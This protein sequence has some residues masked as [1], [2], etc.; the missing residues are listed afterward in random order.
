MDLNK[1]TRK[2]QEA[3][4]HA[5]SIALNLGQQ[6]IVPLHV[7][8]ALIE[9]E[10]TI[11][12]PVLNRLNV[13]IPELTEELLRRL[14]TIPTI[15]EPGQIFVSQEMNGVLMQASKESQKLEDEYMSTEHFLLALLQVK[16]DAQHLLKK[17]G[18]DYKGVLA[19]VK[20]LRG[21]HRVTSPEPETKYQALEKYTM[22]LTKLAREEKLDPV[23]GRDDEIRRAMQVLSRRTKNNPVLIGEPGTGKT[24]IVE[25]LAQRIVAGDVPDSLKNKEVVSLDIGLLLAG[26][27]FRGEFE[28]RM[29]AV[30]KEIDEQAGRVIL[31][32]DELHTIVGA[33]G[34]E[35]TVDAANLL[36]PALARGKLH[37]IGATTLKEYQ[38]YI[39]KDAALERRFQPIFVGEPSV[40]STIAILRGI[41]E[42]YEVHHGVRITDQ[43]IITAA[44]LSHRYIADRFLPDKAIDLIDEAASA[45]RMQIDSMPEELDKMKRRIMQ[46]EVEREALRKDADENKEEISKI[47]KELSE[48]RDSSQQLELQWKNERDILSEIHIK[49]EEIDRLRGEADI[50]EREGDLRTVAEIRYGK[51]PEC[52]KTVDDLQRKLQQMQK[53][54]RILKEEVTDEDIAGVVSRWTGIPVN[55]MLESE[56]QKLEKMEEELDKRVVGQAEA[57]RAIA[58]A[59]RRS[60]AG[61]GEEKRPIGSFIF[62]GPT[63]VGK[64]EL[65]KALADFMFNDS[66]AIVRVDMSEYMEPHSISKIIGSPPGYVGYEES[67]QLTEAIRRRPYSVVLF[68]EIE[69]AHPDVFNI[70]LQVLDDGRITDAKGRKINFKNTIIIMTSNIGS[71]RIQEY[72]QRHGS[73]GFRAESEKKAEAMEEDMRT[74]VMRLLQ[75]SFK[76]EFLNRVDEIII[77]HALSKKNIEQIVNI[78]LDRVVKRLL[79]KKIQLEFSDA[80][81]EYVAEKGYDL[82][83]GARPLKRVIQTDILDPLALQIV[84]G[85]SREGSRVVVDVKK[86][87]IVLNTKK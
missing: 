43:A 4:Q 81:K 68:D 41:K 57:I 19:V 40:E 86:G 42:K 36:K 55:K 51:I 8:Q 84:S 64:T 35:G 67:G 37:A 9:Q 60:R 24:A 20:E 54:Q 56:G 79:E 50:K 85:K 16:S 11:V 17:F 39:E 44:E 34:A 53:K 38:K 33:G 1:L 78:Q 72:A 62:M 15:G 32:I 30:L 59:I 77:F 48:I 83:Y 47:E 6:Q 49:K 23:I 66:E 2:A 29:K 31:F 46:L 82:V 71:Q 25:G 76:P 12:V 3:L 75:D 65:A 7:L 63:G 52:E 80:A 74:D 22:N 21:T 45:L 13:P 58:N 14:S 18:L 69:K 61:V 87:K 27:K 28:E 26:T 70:L 73:M 5:H 10:N